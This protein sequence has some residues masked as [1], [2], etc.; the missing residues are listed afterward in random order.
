MV[1][2]EKIRQNNWKKSL[3][4][5]DKIIKQKHKKGKE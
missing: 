4:I 1:H 2:K 3:R 5:Y